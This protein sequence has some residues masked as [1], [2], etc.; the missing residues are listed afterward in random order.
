MQSAKFL[1][2]LSGK[3]AE[4]WTAT[5]LTPAFV[6][7]G[8]GL[9]VG[10][11]HHGWGKAI[12]TAFNTADLNLQL[13]TS[14]VVAFLIVSTSAAIVQ[15]FEFATIRLLEGYWPSW[16]KSCRRWAIHRKSHQFK[17]DDDRWQTLKQQQLSQGLISDDESTLA[18]LEQSLRRVPVQPQQ[19]MPTHLGNILRAAE[20]RPDLK[21]GLDAVVCWPHLWLLLPEQARADLNA[22]RQTLNTGARVWLWSLLFA[23]VWAPFGL[24]RWSGNSPWP[25]VEWSIW[26]LWPAVLGLLSAWF[27]YGWMLEAAG[28]YGDLIE[29]AFDLYRHAL[30][31]ALRWPL[32][33]SSADEK[34]QGRQ[35]TQYL[36]RG[37]V[38]NPVQYQPPSGK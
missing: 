33:T 11:Q 35:L 29:A 3:L 10:V 36:W 31:T 17:Q 6:F 38:G 25:T 8:G 20:L 4:R 7:W 14:L 13:L 28:S 26:A 9:L 21:Y 32:P 34:T 18:R 5:L 27:A 24:L 1:D 37:T 16:L 30:Y 12:S 2:G 23:L 15:R 22:A 19:L